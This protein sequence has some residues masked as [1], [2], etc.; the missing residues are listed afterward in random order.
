MSTKKRKRNNTNNFTATPSKKRRVC[1]PFT[2]QTFIALEY[3]IFALGLSNSFPS[4]MIYLNI[5]P[6]ISNDPEFEFIYKQLMEYKNG[7]KWQFMRSLKC[8]YCH[9]FFTHHG[10]IVCNDCDN[11]YCSPMC[12]YQDEHIFICN[13][14]D[15][16]YCKTFN[17]DNYYSNIVR[18]CRDCA[19]FICMKCQCHDEYIKD[20]LCYECDTHTNIHQ[21]K[22]FQ[23]IDRRTISQR[24]DK[25]QHYNFSCL[26]DES[27]TIDP[28]IE[29]SYDGIDYGDK[30]EFPYQSWWGTIGYTHN[31]VFK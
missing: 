20:I 10:Q 30:Q 2:I 22:G 26:K 24:Y 6:F 11:L 1:Y 3:S 15:G 31:V 16:E 27:K 17:D 28:S 7:N 29:E 19:S 5:I 18:K 4:Y 8:V 23:D 25:L 21:I 13:K 12:Y 9:C 14:C